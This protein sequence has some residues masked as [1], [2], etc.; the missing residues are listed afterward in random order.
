M[1]AH[2]QIYKLM[3]S[4]L[5][6]FCPCCC[7]CRDRYVIGGTCVAPPYFLIDCN[8]F[9]SQWDYRICLVRKLSVSIRDVDL[10]F[11]FVL[12]MMIFVCTRHNN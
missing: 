9:Y 8:I 7:P 3:Y 12:S 1:P 11:A 10:G 4:I 5:V 2:T 6:F